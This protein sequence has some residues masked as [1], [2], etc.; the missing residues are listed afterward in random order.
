M[1]V[2]SYYDSPVG[3][4]VLAGE[5]GRF[6]LEEDG[7]GPLEVVRAVV[8]APEGLPPWRLRWRRRWS[9]W[10]LWCSTSAGRQTCLWWG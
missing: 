10:C 9:A 7:L 2:T 6:R 4:L 3:R 1:T 5:K 8:Y